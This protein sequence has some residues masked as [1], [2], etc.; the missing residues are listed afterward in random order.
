MSGFSLYF[1]ITSINVSK[2]INS[3]GFTCLF[4][5]PKLFSKRRLY[6]EEYLDQFKWLMEGKCWWRGLMRAIFSPRM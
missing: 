2:V 5:L 1:C 4:C 3:T 6:G